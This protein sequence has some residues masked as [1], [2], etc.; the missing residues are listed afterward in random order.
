MLILK[1]LSS[2]S[3]P[4]AGP[5]QIR[6]QRDAAQRNQHVVGEGHDGRQTEHQVFEPEP[7]ER[8]DGQ[9]RGDDGKDG[10]LF[11]F[12]RDRTFEAGDFIED[13]RFVHRLLRRR[14]GELQVRLMRLRHDLHTAH[15][16][17]TS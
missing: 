14:N 10:R 11:R 15:R 2:K 17:N 7:D 6:R 8:H 5:G 3:E 1:S 13:G 9:K 16:R 4:I 12:P